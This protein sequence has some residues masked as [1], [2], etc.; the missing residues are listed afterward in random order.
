MVPEES[1]KVKQTVLVT[2]TNGYLGTQ[3]SLA[4][5]EA[6]YTV[7]G[8]ARSLEKA[9]N[10]IAKF[11][12]HE[13][14]F[15]IAVVPDLTGEHAYDQA[16]VGVDVVVHTASPVNVA[17]IKDNEQDMLLP[18][19]WGTRNL[20]VA[21]KLEPSIQRVVYTSS[22]AAVCNPPLLPHAGHMYTDDS[23]N[24][25]TY[26][27]AKASDN[28]FF[29]YCASKTLAEQEVWK[30]IKENKPSWHA[31]TICPPLILG[32][33][34][35]PMSSMGSLNASLVSIWTLI[36]GDSNH[37]I[38]ETHVPALTDVRDI[39]KAHVLSAQKE[40]AKN[41]RFLVIA[42]HFKNEEVI[43]M[44]AEAHSEVRDRLPDVS[45]F[46]Y[47]A[48]DHFRSDS[49]KVQKKLGFSFMP[50]DKSIR[51]TIDSLL[52]LDKKLEGY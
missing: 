49:T 30:Y 16:I 39:A 3:V 10:W 45:S 5:L 2:G 1:A 17:S 34:L 48:S 9:K 47:D 8:T 21:T 31:T 43:D 6:G 40:E 18:A 7:R 29:V 15:E 26:D 4:F 42:H 41:E 25:A 35:Q 38:P 20:L 44:A 37:G 46:K 19:I 32:P 51:E 27:E 36:N 28:P 11:P 24:P 14:N 50:K 22:F 33:P 23:W 13:K 12:M 52:E